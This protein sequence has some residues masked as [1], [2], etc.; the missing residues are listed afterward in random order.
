VQSDN[1]GNFVYIIDDKNQA[2]RRGV[3]T[4]EVTEAGVSIA[5]GLNGNERVVLTAGAFLNP[6]QKVIPNLQKSK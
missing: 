6:G 3:T 2:V 1:D 5:S 4:G